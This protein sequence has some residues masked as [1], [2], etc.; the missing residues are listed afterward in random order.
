MTNLW[1]VAQGGLNHDQYSFSKH[2]TPINPYTPNINSVHQTAAQHQWAREGYLST[3]QH[4][5]A[6]QFAGSPQTAY[7]HDTNS[8]PQVPQQVRANVPP[9]ATLSH[10]PTTLI[11]QPRQVIERNDWPHSHQDRKSLM[12]SL[13]QA[14]ARSPDQTRRADEEAGRHYQ[15]VCS[16]AIEPFRLVY[17]H[18]LE[19]TEAPEI[20]LLLCKVGESLPP[21][22][23]PPVFVHKHTN[24]CLRYRLRSCQ[25]DADKA[26]TES[27]WV[28]KE[29]S[30][31]DYIFPHFN[32][33]NLVVR[34]GTHH[35]KEFPV[36]LTDFVVPGLNKLKVATMLPNLPKYGTKSVESTAN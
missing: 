18:E 20:H 10:L 5:P 33:E 30:W 6:L 1:A 21:N 28:T 27:D 19:L 26:V 9:V 22:G 11:P 15:A 23:Q 14:Q 13:H 35:E 29:T 17:F 7:R 24:G 36:E 3:N 25:T 12:M 31:P 4:I 8:Q 32:A 2:H 34:R 16:F